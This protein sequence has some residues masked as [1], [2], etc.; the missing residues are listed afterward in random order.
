M[1]SLPSSSRVVACL[2]VLLA[3]LAGILGGCQIDGKEPND[4]L[5]ARVF[6]KRLYLSEVREIIPTQSTAEDSILVLNAYIE[7][8]IKESLMMHE[9]ERSIPADLEIDELVK[10]YK[11]SLIMHQY[12]KLMVESLLDTVIG[13]PELVD[14]YQANKSQY[15]LES[16]IVQ[17]RLL[18]LPY[19]C[20]IEA[21]EKVEAL[22]ESTDEA[23]MDTLM[24]LANLYATAYFLSDSLWYELNQISKE[25]PQGAINEHVIRNNKVFE[26]SNDDY[27]YFLKILDIKDKKEVAP[28]TYIRDQASQVILHERKIALLEKLK[29][30]L[31]ERAASRNLVKLFTE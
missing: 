7:R 28:L 3:S 27:Y 17:C 30:D 19:E 12:E 31:Y 6:D 9:A 5:L 26:L 8:W 13:E 29:N 2:A 23:D 15:L 20:P 16:I 22:W 11:S 18:K 4:V 25:M 24:G 1:C 14:Y 21:V 10:D